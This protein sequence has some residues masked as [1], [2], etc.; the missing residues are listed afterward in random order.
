MGIEDRLIAPDAVEDMKSSATPLESMIDKILGERLAHN[1]NTK[2]TWTG[3][4]K[5]VSGRPVPKDKV[6]GEFNGRLEYMRIGRGAYWIQNG[7]LYNGAKRRITLDDVDS[8]YKPYVKE[9]FESFKKQAIAADD[10]LCPRC[11]DEGNPFVARTHEE[12]ANHV[13]TV[14][15]TVA[16]PPPSPEPVIYKITPQSDGTTSVE[17]LKVFTSETKP[18]KVSNF[19]C[20][21]CGRNFKLERGLQI[22]TSRIHRK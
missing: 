21:D 9:A 18:E 16:T 2:L 19:L 13:I 11:L 4:T 22:H 1:K 3:N 15:G 20:N 12:Y 17:P 6:T 7:R 8:F 5:M 10:A 14:H